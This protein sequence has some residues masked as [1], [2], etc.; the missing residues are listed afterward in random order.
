MRQPL[1]TPF[2]HASPAIREGHRWWL[3][4]AACWLLT[5]AATASA[6][7]M[8]AA[9]APD[10]PFRSPMWHY[11]LN[12]YLGEAATVRHS[13]AVVLKVPHF[14]EDAT[15][16]PLT[17]DL[18]GFAAE[19]KEVI[20]WVDLNPVP[21]LFTF[22]PEAAEVRAIA[23]NFRIQQAST[24][25]AAVRDAQGCG[26]SAALR[27]MP[28]AGLHRAQRYRQQSRLGREPWADARRSVLAGRCTG[29]DPPE[30]AG[31]ASHG[32]RHGRQYPAFQYRGRRT[33]GQ[34]RSGA[35]GQHDALRIRLGKPSVR[36]RPE[37]GGAAWRD[38]AVDA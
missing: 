10:D 31:H 3:G 37:A 7:G 38:R 22:Q 8:A 15:Q 27:W 28:P 5:V 18:S 4:L 13:D 6:A 33:E 16:V 36:L 29:R 1:T 30:G 21:H 20:T 26:T 14:A 9:V 2:T 24:V 11:N 12:R 23:L 32:F 17:V 35:P 19:V 25:R 34:R